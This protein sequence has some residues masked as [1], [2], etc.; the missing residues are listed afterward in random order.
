M[1]LLR[2]KPAEG[3]VAAKDGKLPAKAAKTAKPTQVNKPPK[4][5]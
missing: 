3:A 5:A 2:K 1:S 4:K